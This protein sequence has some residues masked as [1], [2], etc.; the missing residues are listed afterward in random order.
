MDHPR[1]HIHRFDR[2]MRSTG[3]AE[4]LYGAV[5][6][7]AVLAV[8][9]AHAEVG[10][11]VV[12]STALVS[13]TYWLAHVYADAIGGRFEDTEHSTG[14]RLRHAVANNFGVL[15]GGI[16]PLVVFVVARLLGQDV[17]EAALTALWF[18]VLLLMASAAVAAHKAGA[19]GGTLVGE[20]AVAGGFGLVVILLKIVQ[21]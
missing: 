16:P 14:H 19:R 4:V 12:I 11:N 3:P 5:V 1:K 17:S 7:G 21:H 13:V 9:S 10:E 18:T 2:F 20:T 15:F 6:S 8:T